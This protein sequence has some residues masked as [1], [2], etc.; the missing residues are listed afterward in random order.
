MSIDELLNE[1]SYR[2]KKGYPSV[3]DPSDILILKEILGKLNLPS[4]SIILKLR[5]QE[6]TIP[7][8]YK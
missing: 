6:E 3:D 5:E 8:S 2:T 4:N 7:L 1:W